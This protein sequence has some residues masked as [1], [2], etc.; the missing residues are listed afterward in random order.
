LKFAQLPF[1]LT[2]KELVHLAMKSAALWSL[3]SM[4]KQ[5]AI[6]A[7]ICDQESGVSGGASRLHLRKE[8]GT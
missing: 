5:D 6:V 1:E 8:L 2:P 4:A 7:A 3:K